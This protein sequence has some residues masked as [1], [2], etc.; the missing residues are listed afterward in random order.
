MPYYLA[1]KALH[2]LGYDR[3]TRAGILAE[4]RATRE[5]D[6]LGVIVTYTHGGFD[7][8]ATTA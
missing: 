2:A 3:D 6:G 7:I 1:T 8:Y 4:A 5:W